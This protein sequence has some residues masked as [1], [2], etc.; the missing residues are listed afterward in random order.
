LFSIDFDK[1]VRRWKATS[2]GYPGVNGIGDNAIAAL[3]DLIQALKPYRPYGWHG[4]DGSG[5]LEPPD[6]EDEDFDQTLTDL[7]IAT[8]CKCTVVGC[9]CDGIANVYLPDGD[10]KV[11]DTMPDARCACCMANCP[12]VHG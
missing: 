5:D 9:H 2:T 6:D 1:Q 10:K 11:G 7:G 3:A 12:D 8:G 4:D